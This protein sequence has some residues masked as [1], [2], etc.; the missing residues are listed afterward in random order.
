MAFE[1]GRSATRDLLINADNLINQQVGALFSSAKLAY[2][3]G[4]WL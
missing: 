1:L 2:T 3:L 4:Q